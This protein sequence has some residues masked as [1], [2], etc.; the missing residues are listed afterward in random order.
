MGFRSAIWFIGYSYSPLLHFTDQC[1]REYCPQPRSLRLVAISY[2][3]SILL[4]AL[5]RVSRN[6][7]WSSLH[8]Y[9]GPHKKYLIE[10]FFSSWAMLLSLRIAQKTPFLCCICNCSY[11]DK[12]C[13]VLSSVIVSHYILQQPVLKLLRHLYEEVSFTV[14]HNCR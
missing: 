8:N 11:A 7:T 5:S 6:V 14:L 4:T 12:L 13:T 2:H 1:H 9:L 10:H 3:F